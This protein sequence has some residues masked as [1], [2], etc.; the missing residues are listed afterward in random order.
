MT[1]YICRDLKT[2]H[3]KYL[4]VLTVLAPLFGQAQV[5]SAI[6]LLQDTASWSMNEP[7][8]GGPEDE[9]ELDAP[10]FNESSALILTSFT[11][12]I[13]H[14][15]AYDLYCGWDTRNLFAD[16]SAKENLGNG[17]H[18]QLCHYDCDFEYPALGDVTSPFGPRW[19]RM[20]TGLDIDLE[21]GDNVKAAFEGMVRISQYHASYGNVVVIRH[22]NGLETLYGH[23]SQRKVKPGDHVEAGDLI[24]LGGNTGRSY[25]AHLHF[26]VRFMGEAIDPNLLVDPSKKSLRDWEFVLDKKHFEYASVDPKAIA[27]R[28]G[29]S[30]AQK[31]YHVV[32]KGD[33]LSAVARKHGT[34]IDALCK[35]N[36]LKKSS[37]LKLGQKLR[38]K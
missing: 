15:P 37:T 2:L 38:Y 10:L 26:E 24:G 5:E 13:A 8:V 11:D 36:K 18:F 1:Y 3:W 6:E 20:H 35:L 4:L 16:K 9:E 29:T 14:I 17:K 25:G 33:T 23:L 28:K 12:S 21:T 34:S 19:G 31:K 7:H 30:S 22:N 27:A 32:K